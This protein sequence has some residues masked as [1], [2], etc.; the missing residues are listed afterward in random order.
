MVHLRTGRGRPGV[1]RAGPGRPQVAAQALYVRP[2][3]K[4]YLQQGEVGTFEG[5]E[6]LDVNKLLRGQGVAAETAAAGGKP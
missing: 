1:Q 5:R 4:K 2:F 6:A 3:R